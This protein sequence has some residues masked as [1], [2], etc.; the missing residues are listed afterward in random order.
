M[1]GNDKDGSLGSVHHRRKRDSLGSVHLS[2]RMEDNRF[3]A[4][5]TDQRP[6]GGTKYMV[7]PVAAFPPENRPTSGAE[8]A[9]PE[10]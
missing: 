8:V 2:T 4:W 9:Y 3:C 10:S 1:E 5:G 6:G 7:E